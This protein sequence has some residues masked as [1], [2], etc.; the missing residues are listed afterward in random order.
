MNRREFMQVIS[1]ATT[2]ALVAPALG[3]ANSSAVAETIK[4]DLASCGKMNRGPVTAMPIFDA[5]LRFLGTIGFI[6]TSRDEPAL[7]LPMEAFDRLLAEIR[8]SHGQSLYPPAILEY[9]GLRI[10]DWKIQPNLDR[11]ACGEGLARY[12]HAMVRSSH[13]RVFE[14][15]FFCKTLQ[16]SFCDRRRVSRFPKPDRGYSSAMVMKRVQITIFDD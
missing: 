8:Q 10:G 13:T 14:S 12:L 2:G 11:E 4:S 9:L 1:G 15:G 7:S 16:L 3:K 5:L 6:D